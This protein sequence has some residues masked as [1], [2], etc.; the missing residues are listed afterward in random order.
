MSRTRLG[1][2]I[3]VLHEA[4]FEEHG[5][6]QKYIEWL[7]AQVAALSNVEQAP[8]AWLVTHPDIGEGNFSLTGDPEQAAVWEKTGGAVTP[9]YT[10]PIASG[11]WISVEDRLPEDGIDVLVAYRPYANRQNPLSYY[12]ARLIEGTWYDFDGDSIYDPEFWMALPPAPDA[13]LAQK[14]G[15]K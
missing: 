2:D 4:I 10:S 7:E 13:A 6:A 9:L 8:A 5:T 1:E 12:N 15:G 14:G 3:V 11:A